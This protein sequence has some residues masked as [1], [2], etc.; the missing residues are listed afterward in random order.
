VRLEK[1]FRKALVTYMTSVCLSISYSAQS[2]KRILIKLGIVNRIRQLSGFD[3]RL[4][5][6]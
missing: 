3:F 2:T 5:S 6:L 4:D 1:K